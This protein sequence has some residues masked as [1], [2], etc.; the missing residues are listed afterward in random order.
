MGSAKTKFVFQK[1]M[2]QSYYASVSY[3]DNLL[4]EVFAA[5]EKKGLSGN[6]ITL[7]TGDHGISE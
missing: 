4:G 5:L 1:L 6:T 2:I 7:L 3:I